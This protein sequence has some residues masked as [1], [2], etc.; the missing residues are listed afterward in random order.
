MALALLLISAEELIELGGVEDV[1][2]LHHDSI[3]NVGPTS[4]EKR[5]NEKRLF[6]AGVEL[7]TNS[8]SLLPPISVA[9]ELVDDTTDVANGVVCFLLCL[10]VDLGCLR[11]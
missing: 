1:D 9:V 11:L 8:S 10:H 2:H 3:R 7:L 4:K 6:K 5:R